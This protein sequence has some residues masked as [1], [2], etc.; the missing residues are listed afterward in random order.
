MRSSQG[1]LA[2]LALFSAALIWGSSFFVMK[3]S[4]D[5]FPPFTLLFLRFAIAFAVLSAL[6]QKRFKG[7]GKAVLLRGLVL[8][9]LLFGA[10]SVQTLGLMR[11][12]PG[13]NA[14]LTAV[15]CVLVPFFTWLVTKKRPDRCHWIAA[16]MCLGGIG[17]VSLTGDLRIGAGDGLTLVG[18]IIYAVHMVAVFRF[19]QKEDPVLLTIIQF[20]AAAALSGLCALCME[21]FPRNVSWS[22]WG[23]LMYL[24][25]FA[26]A[27]ALLLQNVGQKYT[28]PAAAAILLSLE[29]VFGVLFSVLF[30]KEQVTARLAAGFALIFLSVVVSETRLG[31]ITKRRKAPAKLASPRSLEGEK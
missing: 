30:M 28:P 11:T 26:T 16:V 4:V 13:K 24:A 8:G 10:Y 20:G 2:R 25:F 19:G 23:G 1:V 21:S 14:F 18:G 6:F 12:T 27:G 5:V 7:A 17:L 22:A 15:Y 9:A 3:N 29:S 31:F